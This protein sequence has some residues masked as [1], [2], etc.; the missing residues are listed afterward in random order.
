MQDHSSRLLRWLGWRRL[1]TAR[2]GMPEAAIQLP[3]GRAGAK[4]CT[5]ATATLKRPATN[6]AQEK[7]AKRVSRVEGADSVE[8]GDSS[9]ESSAVAAAPAASIN[10]AAASV[11]NA[12]NARVDGM[13]PGPQLQAAQAPSS[14]RA[15]ATGQAPRPGTVGLSQAQAP[16]NIAHSAKASAWFRKVGD[17]ETL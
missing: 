1:P 12:D 5:R 9:R 4:T 8:D 10:S 3:S 7:A 11:A 6:Q 15:A 13:P 2:P 14:S 17:G 16:A